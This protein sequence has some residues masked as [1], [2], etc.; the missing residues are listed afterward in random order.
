MKKRLLDFAAWSARWLPQPVKRGL[1]SFQP[2]AGLIRRILN[3]ASPVGLTQVKV[4]AGNLI[5]VDLHLDLQSE[6]DYW[7]GT[8]ELDLQAAIRELVK[9]GMIAYDVGANIGYISLMLAR[10]VAENGHVFSFEAL[11]ENQNR[12][13]KNMESSGL[14]DRITLEKAAVVDQPGK[15]QF[16]IG[17]SGGMGKVVGSAGRQEYTYTQTIQVPGL[18]LDNYVFEQGKPAPH[19][20]KMDIEGGEILALPGMQQ[21]LDKSRPLLMLEL[22]GPQAAQVAW[23]ILTEKAYRICLMHPGFP[24]VKKQENLDWKAYLVAFPKEEG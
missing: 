2:A 5:G 9:P 15:V 18:S 1:Y 4:A 7:L 23:E 8:Y 22:H 16:Q 12:F 11:P 3:K 20:V 10:Q 13:I 21:V 6:K 17:P 19:V 24:Q 14:G